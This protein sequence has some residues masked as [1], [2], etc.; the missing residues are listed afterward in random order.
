ME[1]RYLI[2][3]RR[4]LWL[5]ALAAVVAGL[6]TYLILVDQPTIYQAQTS[7]IIGPGIDTPDPDVN[8]LR[9]G[10][11]LMQTYAEISLTS[12][13]LQSIIDELDMNTTPL[14]MRDSLQVTTNQETQILSF[15]VGHSNPERAIAIANL[16]A[17]KLVE[18]SPS[19]PDSSSSQLKEQM[20]IQAE[21]IEAVI[22]Q[23]EANIR[24]LESDLQAIAQV[25]NQSVVVLQTD[26]YLEKQR[27]IIEQLSQERASLSESLSALTILYETLQ[28]TTTNQVKVIEP[29]VIAM[30][31]PSYLWIKVVLGSAAGFILSGV[32]VLVFA[33]LNEAILTQEEL[34]Q[35]SGLNSLGVIAKHD[36]LVK[37]GVERLVVS[38]LPNS[39]AA[40]NYRSIGTRLLL[41]DEKN[42]LRSLLFST[43]GEES[44]GET[45]L[46]TTNL[47]FTLAKSGKKVALIDANLHNPMITELLN[48]K[49]K[50]G[51]TNVLHN[52]TEKLSLI[53]VD[54]S[55]NLVVLPHGTESGMPFELLSSDRMMEVVEELR[56]DADIVLIDVSSLLT[57]AHSH[58]LA[59]QVDGVV[60]I[61]QEGSVNRREAREL[62]NSLQ[63]L[64]VNIIGAIFDYNRSATALD[65]RGY[66]DNGAGARLESWLNKI[67]AVVQ[68]KTSSELSE[69]KGGV[70][71][72]NSPSTDVTADSTDAGKVRGTNKQ[73][74][75]K[76]AFSIQATKH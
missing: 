74:L 62:I 54:W 35:V 52:D 13:F 17:A 6:T 3:I 9:A 70:K 10:G 33:Y 46:I 30:P 55:P 34:R 39:K 11:Q 7:L 18:L 27:L 73:D 68:S 43:L 15:N 72:M 31:N 71:E 61:A 2:L 45:G 25:E 59:T 41:A 4:W 40:E 21:K 12:P 63:S 50:P 5:L 75:E 69:I 14:A 65:L 53:Q 16:A 24:Q 48:L 47:A 29:A 56:D 51:L 57:F 58:I 1:Q 23:S 60:V 37:P 66:F 49:G 8:A 22:D 76:E 67:T 44:G 36:R 42:G 28:K 26:N 19:G 38:A 32:I 20:R 64:K